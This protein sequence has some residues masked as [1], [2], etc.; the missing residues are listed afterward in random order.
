MTAPWEDKMHWC[1][2]LNQPHAETLM[3]CVCARAC[4]CSFKKK[5]SPLLLCMTHAQR[6]PPHYVWRDKHSSLC[7]L[8]SFISSAALCSHFPHSFIA[9]PHVLCSSWGN[10]ETFCQFVAF[11]CSFTRKFAWQKK[12]RRQRRGSLSVTLLHKQAHWFPPP[13]LQVSLSLSTVMGLKWNIVLLFTLLIRMESRS[14]FPLRDPNPS[15]SV[16]YTIYSLSHTHT[17]SCYT[18]TFSVL[19]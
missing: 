19:T 1:R 10:N 18:P 7:H 8:R 11:G 5:Y 4:E 3:A 9:T 16:L 6:Y 14:C 17:Q 2:T 15:L 13:C 12:R